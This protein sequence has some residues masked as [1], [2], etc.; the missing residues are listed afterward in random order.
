MRHECTPAIH[1]VYH[2]S[3][4]LES[5]YLLDV[6]EIRI[7]SSS[8]V[9]HFFFLKKI[10]IFI[11]KPFLWTYI[12]CACC[13]LVHNQITKAK[14]PNHN[15]LRLANYIVTDGSFPFFFFFY[16]NYYIYQNSFLTFAYTNFQKMGKHVHGKYSSI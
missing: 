8:F 9:F 10:F 13:R 16:N 4:R 12:T 15:I 1:H 6:K 14:N 3:Q 2:L 5:V 11:S 7:P